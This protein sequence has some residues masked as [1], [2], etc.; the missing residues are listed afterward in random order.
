M[1]LN[2]LYH[3]AGGVLGYK[4]KGSV[5]SLKASGVVAAAHLGAAL[6]LGGPYTPV[7]LSVVI[8]RIVVSKQYNRNGFSVRMCQR[9]I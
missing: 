9:K 4:K 7:A 3:A 6:L 1:I 5:A 2:L 8:G